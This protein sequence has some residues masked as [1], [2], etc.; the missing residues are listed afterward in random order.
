MDGEEGERRE[1]TILAGGG[2]FSLGIGRGS[3]ARSDGEGVL[4]G[5]GILLS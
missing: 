4:L 2:V 1:G 3:L 5:W